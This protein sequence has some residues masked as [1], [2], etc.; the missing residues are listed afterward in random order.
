MAQAEL[1]QLLSSDAPEGIETYQPADPNHFALHIQA[2]VGPATK[3]SRFG[4]W[5][6]EDYSAA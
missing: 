6:F 5:E 4:A 3:L 2:F 1:K